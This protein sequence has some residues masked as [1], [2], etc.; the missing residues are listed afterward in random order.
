MHDFSSIGKWVV[1]IGLVLAGIGFLIWAMGKFDFAG[2]LP[3]DLCFEG[4]NFKFYFPLA[5]C[6]LFSVIGSLVLWLFS[7]FK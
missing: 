7:K 3:G 4:Q 2:R 1:L 5:T 6:L